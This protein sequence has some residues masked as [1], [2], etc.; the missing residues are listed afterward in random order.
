[1]ESTDVNNALE[2][3]GGAARALGGG[4]LDPDGWTAV[5]V[6]SG[7]PRCGVDFG[8]ESYPQEAGLKARAVSFNKG[9]YLGQEVICMLENRGQLARRL[10]Q[11]ESSEAGAVD[12]GTQL[13][14]TEGKRVGEITSWTVTPGA[15]PAT[16]ALGY[17][18][19]PFWEPERA[20]RTGERTW[21]VRTV[22]GQ[23]TDECPIVAR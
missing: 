2:R 9:C 11:L 5:H 19:R 10:V 23:T 16:F 14:D 13:F 15:Q 4:V 22:V 3:L 12:P 20:L 18:K 17:V 7:V 21:T 1:V 8:E 6:L